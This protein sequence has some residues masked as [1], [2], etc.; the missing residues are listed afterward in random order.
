M[1]EKLKSMRRWLSGL[2]CSKLL[3]YALMLTVLFAISHLMGLREYTGVISGTI[4]AEWMHAF[5]GLLYVMSYGAFTV[6]VPILLIASV[7]LEMNC[8][9][10]RR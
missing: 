2:E 3:D 8:R 7:L 1:I 10:I 4:S 5:S 6:F 9:F